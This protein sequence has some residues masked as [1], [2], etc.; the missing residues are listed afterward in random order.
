MNTNHP[1]EVTADRNKR[2][3][4]IYWQD[5]HESHYPFAGLRA[6]CPCAECQGGHA[7]MGQPPDPRRVRDEKMGDLNLQAIEAVGGYALQIAW[8]DGHS[9]GIYT[10]SFL[11]AA[12]PCS[13]CLAE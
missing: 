13:L 7:H 2:E 8:S 4:I 11:R 5:G 9:A 10:W 12:C 3:L 6:V 1:A